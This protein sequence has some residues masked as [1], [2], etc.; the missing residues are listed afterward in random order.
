MSIKQFL[1]ESL[2]RLIKYPPE[3]VIPQVK[4][5]PVKHLDLFESPKFSSASDFN[6]K[7]TPP[8]FIR[9]DCLP[10]KP[11]DI[12]GIDQSG[13]SYLQRSRVNKIPVLSSSKFLLLRFFPES[14]FISSLRKSNI[15]F[16]NFNY[17][18]NVLNDPVL[19]KAL[20]AYKGPYRNNTFFSIKRNPLS[21]AVGRSTFRKLIKKGIF[22][23]VQGKTVERVRGFYFIQHYKVPVT[24]EDEEVVR[25]TIKQ[26][27]NKLVKDDN[28]YNKLLSITK[29]QNKSAPRTLRSMI[30]RSNTVAEDQLPL[31]YPKLPFFNK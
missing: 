3:T 7:F 20:D 9:N 6:S 27:I 24:E 13:F 1:L 21:S 11:T 23:A 30:R 25:N 2:K 26:G 15:A 17:P 29:E 10:E 12:R 8:N 28:L 14:H 19:E 5:T 22:E 16:G 4:L 18:V 31:Y